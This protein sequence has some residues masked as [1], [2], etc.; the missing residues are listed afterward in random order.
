M[1]ETR[2]PATPPP[3]YPA[4]APHSVGW[5]TDGSRIGAH[6]HAEG[7]LVYSASGALATT[8]ERGTWVAPANRVTWTPPGFA[9]AHRVYGRTDIRIVVIPVE[10]CGELTGHPSVFAATSLLREAI[11]TL[12]DGRRVHSDAY[13]RLRAVMIDEL[14]DTAEQSLHLPQPQDDRLRAVTELLY[15]DPGRHLT[16]GELGRIA[17]ASDRTLSRLFRNEFGMSFQRWRTILRIHHALIHLADGWSVTD[18]AVE[19]GWSNPTSFIEA[20]TAVV[21]QTPGSYKADLGGRS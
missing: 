20:F 3:T 16:L 8:T 5:L 10:L 6:R 9:H 2:Q 18:T 1:P 15:A 4:G 7:Q 14:A 21:G 11:L 17:G 13:D 12:T 19:C